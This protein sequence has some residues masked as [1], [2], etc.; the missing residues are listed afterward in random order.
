MGSDNDFP[1]LPSGTM[2]IIQQPYPPLIRRTPPCSPSI[3]PDSSHSLRNAANLL[4]FASIQQSRQSPISKSRPLQNSLGNGYRLLP[5][6]MWGDLTVTVALGRSRG[7]MQTRPLILIGCWVVPR[8]TSILDE[9]HPRTL[10]QQLLVVP[11]ATTLYGP[12][13]SRHR[14]SQQ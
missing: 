1:Y 7:S 6:H 3:S 12:L 10:S 11:T 14:I 9:L 5:K 4:R 2:I 13:S 8:R